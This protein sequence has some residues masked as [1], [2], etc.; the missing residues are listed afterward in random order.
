MESNSSAAENISRV[1]YP[2]DKSENGKEL[3]LRQQYFLASAS[4]QDIVR[5]WVTRQARRRLQDT[6]RSK[7][8]CQLN[9]THPTIAVAEL[10][11]LLMDEH[12][13]GWEDGVGHH[14][15]KCLAYTNHTL[16]PEALEKWSV[17]LF[18]KLLPRL[19]DII[20]EINARFMRR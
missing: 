5:R 9:D 8:V 15:A 10:M 6:S 19:L 20:Y 17:G 2:N 1:L 3:R 13:L 4:L 12:A 18:K 14:L 11:R 16:L 7:N